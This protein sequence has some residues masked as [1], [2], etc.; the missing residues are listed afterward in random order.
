MVYHIQKLVDEWYGMHMPCRIVQKAQEIDEF[1]REHPEVPPML[2]E[3]VNHDVRVWRMWCNDVVD[4]VIRRNDQF[5]LVQD[6]CYLAAYPDVTSWH[7]AIGELIRSEP[8]YWLVF[9][10]ED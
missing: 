1:E 3:Y 6:V 4:V 5:V 10:R 2:W 7:K 9:H 8:N